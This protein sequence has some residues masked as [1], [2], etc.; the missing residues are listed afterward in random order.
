[1]NQTSKKNKMKQ[2]RMTKNILH[3]LE[4]R[5]KQI[6]KARQLAGM[7]KIPNAE[8]QEFKRLVK[9]L[10]E[11]GVIQ[12]HKGNRYGWVRKDLEV[13]GVLHVKT[14][15]YGFLIRDDGGQ[16]VFVSQRNM[17]SAIHRDR[18]K[19]RIWAQPVG[20]LPEGKVVD[21]L[22]RGHKVIVGEFQEGRH[23]HFVIPDDLKIGRDIYVRREHSSGAQN[24]QK[25]AVE[26]TD[27]SD[28]RRLP[29]GTV[30]QVLGN[31]G[32]PDADVLSVIYEHGLP[33]SFPKA[34]VAQVKAVSEEITEEEI[35]R[36]H[37]F[38]GILTF[39]ID[40][41]NAKDFDDAVSLE[42]LG[43]GNVRLG[44]HIA[45]VTAY[46]PAG[47]AVDR[48]ALRRGT[49]VYLVDRV[50]PMLPERLS[51]KLCSLVPHED[52]LAFSVIMELSPDAVVQD[53]TICETI[54]N[55][56]HRLTYED[57]KNIFDSE[58][59]EG[60]GDTVNE[61]LVSVLA[62]MRDISRKLFTRWRAA[63]S[64]DFD[65][66]EPSIEVDA[67]GNPVKLGLYP[68]WESHKLVESFMLLANRTVAEHI[69][70]LRTEKKRKYSF[71]YRV[72]EKPSG[73]KL[74]GF[75]QFIRAMGYSFQVGK[76]LTP[77]QFQRFLDSIKGT[78]HEIIIEMV[79]LRSMMKAMY[80]TKNIG[81]FGLAFK[82]YT[83]FTSPIRRYPDLIVHRLLK[84]YVSGAALPEFPANL[85]EIG[86]SCTE[87]EIIAQKAEW[88]VIEVKQAAYMERHIGDEFD[89][90]ISGVTG[91]GFFVEITEFLVEGLVH[92]RELGDDYY[93][94][95]EKRYS[96]TGEMTKKT[97]KLG[98]PV[99]IQVVRIDRA[100]RNIDFILAGAN[101]DQ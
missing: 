19:V 26:I 55:S 29:E 25:V 85:N 21:I 40:P 41:D 17:K 22:E 80:T 9:A 78:R 12:R 42:Y 43:N 11:E 71:L 5:Q 67:K 53:Y 58:N 100:K 31:A 60:R 47:S 27:W 89:G 84:A 95:D 79:A 35:E 45:D 63:G 61:E 74:E 1:M 32:D 16:D 101:S 91:F 68:R 87:R 52:R 65:A 69:H 72:H 33:V 81:H 82:H 46:V 38:R 75:M 30:V 59:G 70:S 93:V 15:G 44:V 20:K 51:N 18:V 34:V 57:V 88:D 64:I 97:Y 6:Y 83:H 13:T 99:R 48:E 98:D 94:F 96:L 90:I 73:K 77:K 56:D 50:I 76:R 62:D 66:P 14:Q 49:S 86:R 39:T 7:L 8:Y 3:A 92:V 37:D 28:G 24:G 2:S 54:I 10:A 4:S 23:N 36:R